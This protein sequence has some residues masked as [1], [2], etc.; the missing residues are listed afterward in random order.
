MKKY[1][2]PQCSKCK[3]PLKSVTE[4]VYER[5]SFDKKSGRYSELGNLLAGELSVECNT[6]GADVSELFHEGA[7]NYQAERN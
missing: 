7:C 4:K 1:K 3:I 2:I 6:C 5:Y